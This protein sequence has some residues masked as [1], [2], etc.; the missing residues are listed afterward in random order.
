MKYN[1]SGVKDYTL[2]TLLAI[3]KSLEK[4]RESIWPDSWESQRME[5]VK[6]EIER[7]LK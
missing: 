2:E 3:L 7:R 5:A 6:K 4:S 1:Q